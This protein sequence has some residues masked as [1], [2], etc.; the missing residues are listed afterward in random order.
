MSWASGAAMTSG[1]SPGRCLA[2]SFEKASAIVRKMS[3]SLFDSQHGG[4]A[5]DSGWMK[6]CMSVELRSS[7]SYQVAAGRT[8]S[9]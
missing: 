6:L 2:A 5:F 4:T 1:V 3:Q 7:F 9:E 8:M